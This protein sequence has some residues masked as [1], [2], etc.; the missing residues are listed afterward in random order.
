[1][2]SLQ[3]GLSKKGQT[4]KTVA[5]GRESAFIIIIIIIIIIMSLFLIMLE[6][7]FNAGVEKL[8]RLSTSRHLSAPE[9]Q[10]AQ[11]LPG[12]QRS[13]SRYNAFLPTAAADDTCICCRRRNVY[14]GDRDM[15]PK[16]DNNADVG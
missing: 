5:V 14:N 7:S 15:S 16:A 12:F 8:P 11:Q 13:Q 2:T 4:D 9:P 10:S 1:M 3:I 6:M